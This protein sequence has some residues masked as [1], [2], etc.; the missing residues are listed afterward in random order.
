VIT[1]IEIID[2]FHTIVAE[3][4]GWGPKA[5]MRNVLKRFGAIVADVEAPKSR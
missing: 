5:Y 2:R 1:I 3:D 4:F